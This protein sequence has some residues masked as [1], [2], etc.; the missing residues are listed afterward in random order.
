MTKRA[1]L[2]LFICSILLSSCYK[3]NEEELYGDSCV[4]VNVSYLTE[5]EPI[6]QNF[7]L[8]C[9]SNVNFSSLGGNIQ[10]ED[11]ADFAFVAGS[12]QLL[13]AIKHETG[14][15]QMPQGSPQ[16]SDCAIETIQ[17]WVEEGYQD[18]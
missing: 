6:I 13:G 11:Y 9:H 15:S 2:L 5:V 1:L 16:L 18:N 4:I 17:A 14:F 3:D 12:G 7:C 10:L 8:A